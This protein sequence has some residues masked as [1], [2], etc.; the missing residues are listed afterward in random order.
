MAFVLDAS[1]ALAWCFPDESTSA[2]YEVL[3]ALRT[4][5][6]L[7]PAIWP[8]EIAN[9][10]L[11]AERRERLHPAD[12]VRFVELLRALPITIQVRSFDLGVTSLLDL[13]RAHGLSA[14]DAAYLELA[15]R[16]GLPLASLDERLRA[17]AAAAGVPRF[18]A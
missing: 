15:A 10:L 3:D 11:V 18:P 16:E 17:A 2:P 1:I 9:A 4:T 8:F 12:S 5:S 14:Y 6:A 7:V 13:A